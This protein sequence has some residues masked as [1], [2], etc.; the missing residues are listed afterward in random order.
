MN[1]DDLRVMLAVHRSG[2]IF[3]A[4]AEL[5]VSRSTVKRRLEALRSSTGVELLERGPE[6]ISLTEAG[7]RLL[8][9]AERMEEE[10]FAAERL[11]SGQSFALQGRLLLTVFE[12]ASALLAPLFTKLR[13][14]HPA[15]E[16]NVVSSNQTL[17]L[18]RR[19][20]DIAVRATATPSPDLFGRKLGT[21]RYAVYG[22][23][24]VIEDR[25]PPW[26]L[27]DEAMGA[28]GSWALARKLGRP[29]Q[30]AARVD[31]LLWMVSLVRASAGVALLPIP[32]AREFPSLV[33]MGRRPRAGTD[34]PIWVL[35]H[36]ELR[37]AARVRAVMTFLGD[38]VRAA[39]Q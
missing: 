20:C 19:E 35:T 29:L 26:I 23:R 38:H 25:N 10:G 34:M 14:A 9:I 31:S 37:R 32:T 1:W 28:D 33:A 21:L 15:I 3:A 7:A 24:E 36:P 8:P 22:T 18:H 5:G 27:P 6:G 11:L 16:L 13:R 30:V 39:L 4:A 17:S 2:T 12:A